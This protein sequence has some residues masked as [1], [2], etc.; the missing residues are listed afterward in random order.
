MS[1]LPL[2]KPPPWIQ[3]ITGRRDFG[4]APSGVHTVGWTV[5]TGRQPV[6]R[7]D[8]DVLDASGSGFGDVRTA[9]HDTGAT[10]GCQRAAVA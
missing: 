3:T 6:I 10:G 1:E 7:I 5:L 8:A 4:V 9:V 2:R